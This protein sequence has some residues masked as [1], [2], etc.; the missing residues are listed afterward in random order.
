VTQPPPVPHRLRRR[1]ATLVGF[2]AF[3]LAA[4]GAFALPGT[5]LA[6][7]TVVSSDPVNGSTIAASPT[8][9][10]FVFSEELGEANTV[11]LD[12]NAELV[13]LGRPVVSDDDLTLTVEVTTA[14]PKGSCV[15]NW[16]VSDADGQPNG[17]G[18]I[19][20]N[21][22]NDPAAVASSTTVAA[23]GTTVA[24]D[25]TA[26]PGVTTPG[27][28]APAPDIVSPA[29]AE[30]GQGPL[31]LGRLVSVL[32]IAVLFGSLLTIAAAW[33][34]GVEYLVAVK[35]VRTVWIVSVVGTVLFVASATAAATGGSF[36]S[37]L[38]PTNWFDLFDAGAPGIAAIARLVLVV[39]SGW[40][41]FRPDR[42]IDPTTQLAGLGIPALAVVTIGF[43]RTGGDLAIVGIAAG[44]VHALAVAI[45]IGGVVL[46][47]RVVLA[48]PGEE[49]L[50]HAVR[51][52]CRISN[53]AIIAT[54]VTG[55]IQTV[56]LD[57]GDLFGSSHGTVLLLKTIAVAVMLFIAIKA[58]QL[59][60][61]RLA[62]ADEM[63]VPMADRLR[64]AFGTEAAIGILAVALSAWLVALAP[65]NAT[66]SSTL[67]YVIE[68][69][70]EVVEADLD[71]TVKLSSDIVGTVGI[72][73]EVDAPDSG[74]SGLEIVFTAPT[75]PAVDT[76]TQPVPLPGKGVAVR[77]ATNGL[78]LTVAGEWKVQ[79]NA[80]TST[81][82]VNAP[83][84]VFVIRNADG[85]APV[86]VI[87]VPPSVA[88]STTTTT[89]I[90]G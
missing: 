81:G 61:E 70:F 71:V 85:S 69:Q 32:G 88:G 48:G 55:L 42:V 56:R 15:A 36:G 39:G 87:T 10:S 58:R 1:R 53:L 30:T 6:E 57:G 16:R 41:A 5:A 59:V 31:W 21:V 60:N 49:D 20:F 67:S 46:I 38:N 50:V 44:V 89:T 76:I 64:R 24:A 18:N 2:A 65:P 35:F 22:S 9:I 77:L 83:A 4:I 40:V 74:L 14:L 17:A 79:V 90:P 82:V 33:P 19:T 73:I 45:W 23:A 8:E 52:F 86:T 27:A 47:A 3:G 29:D 13:S 11:A 78:P 63:S 68:R 26:V 80:V 37:G 34:E 66:A 84:Q 51:G 25:G 54:V 12:C 62:R 43:S 28:T 75:N 72:E 7:A